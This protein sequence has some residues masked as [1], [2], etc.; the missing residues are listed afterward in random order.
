MIPG[1]VYTSTV[2][3]AENRTGISRS[4]TVFHLIAIIFIF[5]F[6]FFI[7]IFGFF[8]HNIGTNRKNNR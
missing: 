6:R 4:P 8:D 3:V 5:I 1:T 7:Y 2:T